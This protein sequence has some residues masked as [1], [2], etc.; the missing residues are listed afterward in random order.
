MQRGFKYVRMNTETVTVDPI[1]VFGQ[2]ERSNAI[3]EVTDRLFCDSGIYSLDIHK[4][5]KKLFYQEG[6]KT[7]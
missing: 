4:R 6:I 1:K 3:H 2:E 7:F 5:T